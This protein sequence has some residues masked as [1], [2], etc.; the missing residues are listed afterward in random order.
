VIRWLDSLQRLD[1]EGLAYVLI[2]IIG[3]D[4]SAPREP[5]TRMIVEQHDLHGSLGGGNLEY[6]AV[7]T[8]RELL[9]TTRNS[10]RQLSYTLG[11]DLSQCCG[12]RVTL[13]F[14]ARV[15][16][17]PQV[18]LFG[19]GHVGKALIQI[20]AELDCDVRWFDSRPDFLPGKPP[21]NVMPVL[22]THAPL[23]VEECPAGSSFLV[24][25][26]SHELD[27]DI[28]EAAL[29]RRDACYCSLIAS[30]SKAAKFRQR[31]KRKAFTADEI[32]KLTAPAGLSC[33]NS[34][35]PMAVAVA[36]AAQLLQQQTPMLKIAAPDI[37]AGTAYAN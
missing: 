14:E 9:V 24:M 3:V 18:M 29:S 8:A 4:G 10:V 7:R 32:D 26:H 21:P 25:T 37:D 36:I 20:L 33:F 34:N 5:G 16:R 19:A 12:G 30:K 23:A 17:R 1:R 6:Q 22:L 35:E 2:T 31:L 11:Q 27:F 13:L 15:V 28:V